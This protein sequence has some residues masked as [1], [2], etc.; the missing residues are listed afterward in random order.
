MSQYEYIA[1]GDILALVAQ[2]FD[3]APYISG[4]ND[5]LEYL[6]YSMGVT[7]S[8]ISTPVHHLIKE[9]GKSLCLRDLYKDKIGTNNINLGET[10]K[11][12]VLYDIQNKEVERL[13]RDLTAEMFT[14]GADTPSELTRTVLTFRG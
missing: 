6:A 2:D 9:Y 7:P 8:G 3:M 10:D 12:I 5:S 4:V 11:Y 14:G 13:R 1:S